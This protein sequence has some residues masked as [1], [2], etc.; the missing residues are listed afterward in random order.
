MI[1][2]KLDNVQKL[3]IKST[4]WVLGLGITYYLL[5][6]GIGKFPP[7]L[8]HKLTGFLCCGCGATRMF[9]D[10]LHFDF[11]SAY[12]RNRCLMIFLILWIIYILLC[13]IGKPKCFRRKKVVYGF[14]YF[15]LWTFV[16][17]EIIRNIY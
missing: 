5:F 15:T 16:A 14:L 4:L 13:F 9:I 12:G 3:I 7:C 6:G 10:I 17:W 1:K 2:F 11:A 8:F